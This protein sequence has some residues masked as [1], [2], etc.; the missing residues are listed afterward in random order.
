MADK[1]GMQIAEVP[2][3]AYADSNG[4]NVAYPSPVVVVTFAVNKDLPDDLV[5]NILDALWKHREEFYAVHRQHNV[6][7][8]DFAQSNVGGA[9]LHPGADKLYA[10]Q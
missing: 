7:K 6:F 4:E 5:Y 10:E 9:P 1:Y 3:G 2:A 8:L